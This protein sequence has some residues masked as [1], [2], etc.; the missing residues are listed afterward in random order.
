MTS[1]WVERTRKGKNVPH[2]VL[3]YFPLK[4]RLRKLY[5]SKH[6]AKDTQWHQRGRSTEDD[7]MRDPVDGEAWKEFDR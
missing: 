6:I 1:R 5:S 2:K 4:D 3:H 7:F